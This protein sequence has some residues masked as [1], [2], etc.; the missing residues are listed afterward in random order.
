MKNKLNKKKIFCT[1]LIYQT[2][3]LRCSRLTFHTDSILA[4]R[5]KLFQ[6]NILNQAIL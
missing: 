5:K 4:N 3:Y 2:L 6:Q 1:D